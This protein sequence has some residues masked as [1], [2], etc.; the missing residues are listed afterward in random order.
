MESTAVA[1]NG[2]LVED[3][4]GIY[5]DSH[6]AGL[7]AVVDAVHAHGAAAGIQLS[8]GG[9]KSI[10]VSGER[11]VAPTALAYDDYFGM[12]NEITVEEIKGL[13]Q[14]YADSAR[15]SLAAGFDLIEIHA[16]HGFLVHQ[17]LSPLTNQRTDE[18]GGSDENRSRF[19][20]EVFEAVRAVVGKHYPLI[21]R[22]SASDYTAGGLTPRIVANQLASLLPLGLAAVDVSSGWLNP[23]V[24]PN[25]VSEHQVPFATEIKE[26]LSVPVIAVGLIRSA[27]SAEKV[28]TDGR[29]DFI[30]IGRPLLE[31]PDYANDWQQRLQAA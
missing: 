24:P 21:V 12:P 1:R 7:K 26:I 15:R 16:A 11:L 6:I 2:R 10:T 13:V 4:I 25:M 9:R 29:A 22:V 3:D 23:E 8:H 19:M 5:N 31:R 14:C 30:A 20:R 27:D 18:Y 17:F 28:L